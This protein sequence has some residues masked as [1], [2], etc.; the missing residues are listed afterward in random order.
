VSTTATSALS[1]AGIPCDQ[2][3]VLD[4]RLH[5]F[6]TRGDH[7]ANSW[8][9]F[10]QQPDF[11]CGAFGCW[12]RQFTTKWSDI[13][14]SQ[15]TPDQKKAA[16]ITWQEAAE[17]ARA[18]TERA[19]KEARDSMQKKLLDMPPARQHP[20][21]N[22]KGVSPHGG[23]KIATDEH[24]KGWLC[25]PLQDEHRVTHS[26]QFIADD[27]TK[28]FF[29]GGRVQG[30]YFEIPGKPNGPLLIC[31]GYATG[32]S[33]FE[34]TGWTVICAMNCGNLLSVC[35]SIC[36]LNPNRTLV[37]CAD[38]DQ[39]TED[40]PGLTKSRAAA[41]ACSASVTWPVF[42]AD[43]LPE[44]P[45]DFNDLHQNEGLGEVRIQVNRAFSVTAT[46]IGD[47][48]LPPENDP[49]ELL[50]FRYLC[51]RGSLLLTGPTGVGKSSFNLQA[52]AQW[53]VNNP[54]FGIR[55]ARPLSAVLI[56]AE[57][58]DGDMAE[59]RDGI[60]TGLNF[61]EDQ[62]RHFFQNVMVHNST[63]ITGKK[64]CEEVVCPLLDMHSPDLL[65]I[66]PALSFMGGD[67]KE[68]KDVG[69]FLRQHLNPQLYAH[70]CAC[71]MV[72][73]TN[74]P[75]TGK[76]ENA[77][78]NGE[79]AYQG[80]GSAEWANWPRGVISLSSSGEP[81]VYT[82]HLGKRGSR[83]GWRTKQDEPEY[84]RIIIHSRE[85][86]IICWHDGTTEDLP[87]KGGRPPK[88]DPMDLMQFLGENGL[89]TDS[90]RQKCSD[91]LGVSKPNF[92]RMLGEMKSARQIIRNSPSSPWRMTTKRDLESDL[93]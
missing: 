32:C 77:P 75:K 87:D 62:R 84:E 61:S 72:H 70:N 20:Y 82:L 44:K 56:Q 88:Y 90:W 83:I 89:P 24:V 58:D 17:K 40:N 47:L 46:A 67:V 14:F 52:L 86:G 31:E 63:G 35:Q 41:K 15:L 48:V 33:L 79:W 29:F 30:C 57:N 43:Q 92:Y 34:A 26:A 13:E 80:S 81:G 19:Q 25:V 49:T 28:R 59:M 53:S 45:T 74:K 51:Q 3:V 9:V 4:G 12:K 8:Y 6:R 36:R 91:E 18:E 60:C 42:P 38:N 22:T 21:T 93:F 2:Q 76:G 69:T 66:D 37:I 78:M 5:R 71:L 27:G 68:Q 85:K 54:F 65:V 55:P 73:H 64:F 7:D 16:R 10:H 1:D 23:V 50:K 39:F 11:I